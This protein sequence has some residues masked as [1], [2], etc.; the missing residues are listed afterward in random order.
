MEHARHITAD[1]DILPSYVPLPGLGMLP[2]N[3]YVIKGQQPVLVDTGLHQDREAFLR[4]LESVV[5][6]TDLRWIWLTH[7]DQDHVGALRSLMDDYPQI[8]L[9]TTFLGFGIISLF[10]PLPPDRVY[11]LNPGEEIDLGD[12]RLVCLRPPTFDNPATTA[13]Y[14]TKTRALLSSDSF[15]GLLQAPADEAFGIDASALREGQVVWATVDAPWLH[16]VDRDRYLARLNAI[17][18]LDP[19]MV[20]SAHLPPARAMLGQLLENL[21]LAPSARPFSGPNQAAF[22]A[23]LAQMTEPVA[24]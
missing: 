1:L 17:R 5:D 20:L 3:S 21:A 23:M 14:D 24:A 4:A 16:D 6:P 10:S 2:V 18:A 9:I 11:F 22:Q 7:P 15:G 19:V 13:L 12:R 8:R